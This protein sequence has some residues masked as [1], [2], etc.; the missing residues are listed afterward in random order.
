MIN[1]VQQKYKKKTLIKY[2]HIVKLP[3]VSNSKL[4]FSPLLNG[5]KFL[6][7]HIYFWFSSS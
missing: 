4:D 3:L 2:I 6:S 1:I 7:Q 5:K